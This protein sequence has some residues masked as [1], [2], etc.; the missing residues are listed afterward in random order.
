MRSLR[1][2]SSLLESVR[3]SWLLYTYVNDVEVIVDS[4]RNDLCN[5]IALH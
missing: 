4:Q 2:V 3:K 5:L 1:I